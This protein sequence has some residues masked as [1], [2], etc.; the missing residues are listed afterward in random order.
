MLLNSLRR[1]KCAGVANSKPP[2]V[3]LQNSRNRMK[4]ASFLR[5][6]DMALSISFWTCFEERHSSTRCSCTFFAA[7]WGAST[8]VTT[9]S[10]AIRS[11]PSKWQKRSLNMPDLRKWANFCH[12]CMPK[13][14]NGGVR[15]IFDALPFYKVCDDNDFLNAG[16]IQSALAERCC[17]NDWRGTRTS[18]FSLFSLPKLHSVHDRCK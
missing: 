11:L 8:F 2:V 10:V 14:I 9:L 12:K 15:Y 13:P 5:L 3:I 17:C 1:R 4:L 6:A 7:C 16:L 18:V